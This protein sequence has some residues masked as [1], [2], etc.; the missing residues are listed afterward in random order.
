MKS[1]K[2]T[3]VL[4]A[5]GAVILL[6]IVASLLF[7]NN[8]KNNQENAT[9]VDLPKLQLGETTK[10]KSEKCGITFD[11]PNKWEISE[12]KLPLNREPLEMVLFD[13]PQENSEGTIKSIL[14]FMCFDSK[15]TSFGDLYSE[16]SKTP[17]K[18]K[19]GNFGWSRVDSF[20]FTE[21]NGK[22][23]VFQMNNTK[24]DVMRNASYENVFATILESVR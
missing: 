23:I 8:S 24:Y 12:N 7:S 4:G 10:Y 22:L 15:E 6:G 9:N 2:A 14:T 21:K 19:L 13:V 16:T 11:Y 1:K 20:A 3:L 5:I 17:K 18:E